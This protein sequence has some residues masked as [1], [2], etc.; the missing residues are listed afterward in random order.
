MRNMIDAEEACKAE[1]AEM[2]NRV[3]DPF[4]RRQCRP[5]IV[6]KVSTCHHC[7]P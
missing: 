4:T 5:T 2:K 3:A 7:H 1:V 6:T